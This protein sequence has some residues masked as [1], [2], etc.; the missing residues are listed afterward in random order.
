MPHTK[1]RPHGSLTVEIDGRVLVV[2]AQGPWNAELSEL[3]GEN[4]QAQVNQL[5]GA[6]WGLLGV[7]SD[8]GVHTPDSFAVSVDIVRAHRKLGRSASAII[9]RYQD[10]PLIARRVFEKLYNEAGEPHAFFEDEA[11]AC[12]WLNE[13]ISSAGRND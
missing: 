12:Q 1:F 2:R 10:S 5:A 13:Q 8:E 3:Y 11:A 6:P 7:I 4:V 9:F